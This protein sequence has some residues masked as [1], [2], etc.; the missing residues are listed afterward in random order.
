VRSDRIDV[1]LALGSEVV[2]SKES[3]L[4]LLTRAEYKAMR[5]AG[6]RPSKREGESSSSSRGDDR[7][8]HHK[9]RKQE[10][11]WLERNIR[12]R[13]VSESYMGGRYYN[14]KVRVV[15]VISPTRCT[16]VRACVC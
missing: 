3:D 12:V 7:D 4:R 14:K 2:H 15:D 1:E 11:S 10:P 9:K 5:S 8:S 13:I 16:C 6:S